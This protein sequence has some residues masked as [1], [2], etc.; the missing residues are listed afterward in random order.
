MSPEEDAS[1][2]TVELSVED[3]AFTALLPDAEE[4]ARRLLAVTLAEAAPHLVGRALEV[5]V[6]LVDDAAI[7]ELNRTFRHVDRPTDVLSFPALA[8]G[9]VER[10]PELPHPL[11]LGDVVIARE[12]L[13]R[14]AACLG[15]PVRDHFAHLLVHGLLHLLGHD[16]VEE[17]EAERMEAL[18][19]RILRRLGFADPYAEAAS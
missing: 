10:P 17:A 13:E 5:G 18:E 1:R 16:H 2:P 9:E 19:S 14:E 4:L 12:T 6:R 7:R 15:R 8:P 3:P 11:P